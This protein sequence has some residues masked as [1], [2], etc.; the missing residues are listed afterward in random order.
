MNPTTFS[1]TV[2]LFAAARD[3]AGC[4]AMV[5]EVPAASTVAHVRAALLESAPRLQPMAGSLLWA[6]NNE[7]SNDERLVTA[8]DSI[9]CFPPVSGG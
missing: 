2:H 6:V 3:A 4:S 7:Y 9:A 1:V 8:T 5:L